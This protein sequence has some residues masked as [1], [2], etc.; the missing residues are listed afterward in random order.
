MALESGSHSC[1]ATRLLV[2]GKVAD[3]IYQLSAFG[4]DSRRDFQQAFLNVAALLASQVD[5]V[6]TTVIGV[7]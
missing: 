4:K 1:E 7:F 6:Q 2:A 3:Q 5:D